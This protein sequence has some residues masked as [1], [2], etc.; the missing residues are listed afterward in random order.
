M[1]PPSGSFP[2][3]SGS[4]VD[5]LAGLA[6]R[7]W[8]VNVS[9]DQVASLEAY[10]LLLARWNQTINLTALGLEGFPD[11]TLDRLLGEPLVAAR[12]VLD[13]TSVWFDLGSG[14]GTPAI[15]LKIAKPSLVLTMVESRSRKA[16]FLGEAVRALRLED[17]RVLPVRFEGLD[18]ATFG[19]ADLVTVR[20]VR[21]DGELL[22]ACAA[23]L[24]SGGRLQLF[25][26]AAAS[27][28]PGEAFREL[29]TTCLPGPDAVLRAWVRQ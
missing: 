23:L 14:G 26:A 11:P 9:A 10:L 21:V 19:T 3:D 29:S 12:S 7:R 22:R 20:A 25:T 8:R 17:A 4:L 2:G 15:P 5:R 6:A 18:Q 13:A 28:T 1:P 16:A 27:S 24:K